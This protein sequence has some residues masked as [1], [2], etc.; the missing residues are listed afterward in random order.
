MCYA[1]EYLTK[2]KQINILFYFF[3]PQVKWMYTNYERDLQ[4][5]VTAGSALVRI[6]GNSFRQ[7]LTC[8]AI[9]IHAFF[10]FL[11]DISGSDAF[12]ISV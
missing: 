6:L 12:C 5:L 1:Y 9:A 7:L 11:L 10:F 2:G 3:R 4:V 8:F